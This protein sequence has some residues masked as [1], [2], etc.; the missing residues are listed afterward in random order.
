MAGS[1]RAG[2][3]NTRHHPRRRVIQYAAAFPLNHY[4]RG[5]LGR[6]VKPGDDEIS[7]PRPARIV[8]KLPSARTTAGSAS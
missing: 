5:V 1:P 4:R 8:I 2:A 7:R 6:P 3:N